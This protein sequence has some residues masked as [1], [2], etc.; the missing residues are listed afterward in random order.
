MPFLLLRHP[1]GP[2]WSETWRQPG[3]HDSGA[4]RP[5]RYH[6]TCLLSPLARSANIPLIGRSRAALERLTKPLS[7][8]LRNPG[9][10]PEAS[11]GRLRPS[12]VLNGLASLTFQLCLQEGKLEF[13]H[14]RTVSYFAHTRVVQRCSKSNRAN[15]GQKADSN[16]NPWICALTNSRTFYF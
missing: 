3:R 11:G 4:L 6:F 10:K 16:A 7:Q 12:A 13:P 5:A 1:P 15:E 14:F 2:Q 9:T 8:T